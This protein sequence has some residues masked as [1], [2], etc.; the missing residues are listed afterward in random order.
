MQIRLSGPT[1]VEGHITRDQAFEGVGKLRVT[2]RGL[3]GIL[4]A[5]E[6]TDW[7]R[8]DLDGGGLLEVERVEIRALESFAQR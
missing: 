1:S 4:S 7:C 6:W 5:Y 8:I 3:E 2:A